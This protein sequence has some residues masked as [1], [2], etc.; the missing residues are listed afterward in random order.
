MA[1]THFLHLATVRPEPEIGRGGARL[2]EG[3]LDFG[4]C[5][6]AAP[7][8]CEIVTQTLLPL[9]RLRGADARYWR[10]TTAAGGST[11]VGAGGSTAVRTCCGYR[12]PEWGRPG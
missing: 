4:P 7:F 12:T 5:S 9:E 11:A 10:L 1:G 3:R 8:R 6:G 2:G